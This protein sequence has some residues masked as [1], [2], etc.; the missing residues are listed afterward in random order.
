LIC[1]LPLHLRFLLTSSQRGEPCPVAVVVGM[2]PALFMVAGLEIPYGKN[3]YDVTGGPTDPHDVE[4]G[5]K[6]GVFTG[7]KLYPA[8]A[9]TNSAAPASNQR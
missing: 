1:F 7:V 5:F 9:T 2:H 6:D 4:R 3:E 8:N